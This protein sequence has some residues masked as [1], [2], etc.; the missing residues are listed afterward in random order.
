MDFDVIL[1]NYFAKKTD[2]FFPK[3]DRWA[4]IAF[5]CKLEALLT[6]ALEKRLHDE[7]YIA[8]AF[9]MLL[10]IL[11]LFDVCLFSDKFIFT[12]NASIC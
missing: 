12:F 2:H 8:F 5:Q 4:K 6:E 11:N 1:C 9:E 3:D 7:P 10:V